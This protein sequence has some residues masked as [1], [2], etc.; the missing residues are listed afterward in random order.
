METQN[1]QRCLEM[2]MLLLVVV[3][4]GNVRW[5]RTERGV[6][7]HPSF[8]RRRGGGEVMSQYQDCMLSIPSL[9]TAQNVKNK[10]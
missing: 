8:F 3:G 2:W 9:L 4:C 7:G 6:S 10:K 1:G 5:K